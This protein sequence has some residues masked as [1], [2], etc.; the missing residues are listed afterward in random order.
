MGKKYIA[1][2]GNKCGGE[3]SSFFF[4]ELNFEN[5]IVL[6]SDYFTNDIGDTNEKEFTESK[7]YNYKI[8]NNYLTIIG[9]KYDGIEITNNQLKSN[10]LIFKI[11]TENQTLKIFYSEVNGG[12][13]GLYTKLEITVD[14]IKY[15]YGGNIVQKRVYSEKT[16]KQLWQK[17]IDNLDINELKRIDQIPS[18]VYSY[19][20]NTEIIIEIDKLK[21]KIVNPK[22]NNID[23][24]TFEFLQIL[25]RKSEDKKYN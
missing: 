18:E 17:L 22:Q 4:T 7:K 8:E 25:W 16:N 3:F 12:K 14:S 20:L 9:S 15:Q 23:K 19:G 10:K 5:D 13:D 1:Y 21:F 2:L 11:V 24:K 6:V